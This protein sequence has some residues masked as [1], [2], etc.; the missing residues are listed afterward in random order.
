M[1]RSKLKEKDSSKEIQQ[2]CNVVGGAGRSDPAKSPAQIHTASSYV[3]LMAQ[4]MTS[5]GKSVAGSF[6]GPASP[7]LSAGRS[8]GNVVLLERRG[9]ASVLLR[10][11]CRGSRVRSRSFNFG[12]GSLGLVGRSILLHILGT[13]MHVL[14]RASETLEP[15]IDLSHLSCELVLVLSEGHHLVV[16]GVHCVT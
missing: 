12:V 6:A 2:S 3:G 8:W 1:F 4:T 10:W 9:G 13:T 11:L 5:G 14:D 16:K 15:G 7:V